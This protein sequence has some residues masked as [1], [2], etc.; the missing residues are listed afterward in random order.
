MLPATLREEF[1]G[2]RDSFRVPGHSSRGGLTLPK[3]AVLGHCTR[4]PLFVQWA[5]VDKHW[6]AEGRFWKPELIPGAGFGRIDWVDS[7]RM[8]RYPGVE[9]QRRA[10]SLL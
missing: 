8:R 9:C 1:A 10:W 4:S 5:G 3:K 6:R 7:F 2:Y